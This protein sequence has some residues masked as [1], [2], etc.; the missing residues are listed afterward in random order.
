MK[1]TF[2]IALVLMLTSGMAIAQQNGGG[3]G[4]QGGKGNMSNNRGNRG[5]P[6]DRMTEHLGLDEAQAAE[7]ALIFEE[8]QALR[9]EQREA[10]RAVSEEL[11]ENT[12]LQILEVLT[13]EQQA[14]FEEQRQQR[15]QMKQAMEEARADRGFGG[16][17]GAGGCNS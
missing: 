12:H 16:G 17:R 15:E 5:N 8:T 3:E 4:F 2:L 9:E 13:P 6:V 11:R 14:L 1:K 10:C 7:I